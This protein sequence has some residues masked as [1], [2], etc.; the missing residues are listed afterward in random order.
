MAYIEDDKKKELLTI[1]IEDIAE[2]LGIRVTRHIALCFLHDDHH[3]SLGFNPAKNYWRCYACNQKGDNI[4]LVMKYNNQNFVEACMWLAQN[5]HIDIEGSGNYDTSAHVRVLPQPRQ[6]EKVTPDLEILEHIVNSNKLTDSGRHF[7]INERGY[8]EPMIESLRICSIDNE[9]QFVNSLIR[10]FGEQRVLKAQLAYKHGYKYIS[11]FH[12]PCLF[13]PYY[14]TAGK[15]ISLQARYLGNTDEHQRFQFPK[16]SSTHIFNLQVLSYL[17]NNEPLFIAEGV[18][19][20]LALLSC[21]YKAVAIPSATLLKPAELRQVCAHPLLMY[22]DNDEP[23]QNLYNQI[24]EAIAP[25]G[26]SITKLLLPADC[27]DFSVF[28]KKHIE[29]NNQ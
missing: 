27:K 8:S 1:P 25:L 29:S 22:P 16:G 20:T 26:V 7:L 9:E 3:P 21:G 28:Y 23:G 10:T 6:D 13:F 24:K 5:F 14:D 12:A 19:D 11:Y 18:T 15:L 2:K 4:S 17:K